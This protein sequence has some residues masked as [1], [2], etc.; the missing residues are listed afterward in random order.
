MAW[1]TEARKAESLGMRVVRVRT[2][3]VLDGRGGAL[4]KM[5]PPF[6]MGVG[7]KLGDGRSGW[8]DPSGGSGGH[9]FASAW[10]AA[11]AGR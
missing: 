3:L 6:R 10:R 11:S 4:Q 9:F 7:G 2:G 1:E 8:L 5:L